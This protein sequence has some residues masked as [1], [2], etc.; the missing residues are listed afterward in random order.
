MQK[1]RP[2]VSA[3]ETMRRAPI[4]WLIS[5]NCFYFVRPELIK[6]CSH[7]NS[8]T[9]TSREISSYKLQALKECIAD[10]FQSE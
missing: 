6:H 7:F 2:D 8:G 5:S 10:S 9:K 3:W 1:S 4:R